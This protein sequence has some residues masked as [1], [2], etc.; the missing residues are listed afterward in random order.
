VGR[1]WTLIRRIILF[2]IGSVG[3]LYE[4]FFATSTRPVLL[5]TDL[6]LVG[7]LPVEL[8]IEALNKG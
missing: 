5:V 1:G 3:L 6:V 7:L 2:T 8:I 4:I